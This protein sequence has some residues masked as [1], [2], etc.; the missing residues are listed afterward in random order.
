MEKVLETCKLRLSCHFLLDQVLPS[1]ALGLG[2]KEEVS[3]ACLTRSTYNGQ[4]SLEKHF[5]IIR[6][7]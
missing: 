2:V 7:C 1:I 5:Q 6:H 4:M 3:S